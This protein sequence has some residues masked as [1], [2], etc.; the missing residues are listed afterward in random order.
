MAPC[1]RRVD[2]V[3]SQV[4]SPYVLPCVYFRTGCTGWQVHVTSSILWHCSV[5][6]CWRN[7]LY[8]SAGF[9]MGYRFSLPFKKQT[10]T[11]TLLYYKVRNSQTLSW[12]RLNMCCKY[13]AI[14]LEVTLLLISVFPLGDKLAQ[15][16]NSPR[17]VPSCFSC[18]PWW[19]RLPLPPLR[20]QLHQLPQTAIACN[21]LS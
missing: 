7:T 6:P 3:C 15:L 14:C 8:V 13:C 21:D 4:C 11:K 17:A 19:W 20:G 12:S 18:I 1:Y 10:T 16:T 5:N 2:T 9:E